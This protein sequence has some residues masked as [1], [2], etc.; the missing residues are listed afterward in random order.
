MD[1]VHKRSRCTDN[2]QETYK[3]TN[4]HQRVFFQFVRFL[5]LLSASFVSKGVGYFVIR[6]TLLRK[7][8]RASFL[9]AIFRYSRLIPFTDDQPTSPSP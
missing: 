3:P 5:F 4:P 1:R 9:L 6:A 2:G 8:P 7:P